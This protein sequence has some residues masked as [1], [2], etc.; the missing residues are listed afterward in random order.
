[1]AVTAAKRVDAS[2]IFRLKL[3]ASYGRGVGCPGRNY[4]RLSNRAG[5]WQGIEGQKKGKQ[6]QSDGD[7]KACSTVRTGLGFV[8]HDGERGDGCEW[9]N[10]EENA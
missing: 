1:M 10:T 7:Q 6:E 3:R 9:G 4:G 5:K 8:R 2:L